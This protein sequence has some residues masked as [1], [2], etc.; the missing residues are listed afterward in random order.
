MSIIGKGSEENKINTYIR[1]HNLE[2]AVELIP[3]MPRH[4]LLKMLSDADIYFFP[5]LREGGSWALMEA[6]AVGLPVVCLNWT[7][8]KIITDT[9]SAIQIE[10]NEYEQI[11]NGFTE[12]LGKLIIDRELRISMG[13]AARNRIKNLFNWEHVGDQF[14]RILN[15]YEML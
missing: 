12:G 2:T 9:N 8:M 15:Q 4:Q 7:G 6:M 10:P 13:S 1:K 3:E 14:N 5:S 11:K